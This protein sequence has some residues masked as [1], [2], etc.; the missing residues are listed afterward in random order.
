MCAEVFVPKRLAAINVAINQFQQDRTPYPFLSRKP[1]IHHPT[2]PPTRPPLLPPQL[3]PPPHAHMH[4]PLLLPLTQ[5]LI[6]DKPQPRPDLVRDRLLRVD[7]HQ[8]PPVI[9]VFGAH[10][11]LQAAVLGRRGGHGRQDVLGVLAGPRQG[12]VDE[13][14]REA[15]AWWV[16]VSLAIILVGGARALA[17]DTYLGTAGGPPIDPA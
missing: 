12:G 13:E 15:E 14:S 8:A 4:D 5:T 10:A 7:Q 16:V 11:K 1:T 3:Y 9:I 6:L 2:S 17:R